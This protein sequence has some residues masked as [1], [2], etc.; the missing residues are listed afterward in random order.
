VYSRSIVD[1]LGGWKLS[2]RAGRLGVGLLGAFDEHPTGSTIAVD[3]ATGEVLPGWGAAETAGR[4]ALDQVAR[5]RWD[6]GGGASIGALFADR[7]L[8]PWGPTPA[9]GTLGN[10]VGAL[11]ASVPLSRRWRAE[12]QAAVSQT[13]LEDGGS[14]AGPAWEAGVERVGEKLSVFLEQFGAGGGFRA[15]NGFLEE[16]G[17]VGAEAKVQAHFRSLSFSRSFSPDLKGEVVTDFAGRPTEARLGPGWEV[18]L[19]EKAYSEGRVALV[20]ERFLGRDFDRWRTHGF[21]AVPP[22][23]TSNIYLDWDVGPTPH[24]EATTADDLFLGFAWQG[25]VGGFCALGG[26]ATLENDLTVYQFRRS[27]FGESVYDA[28]IDRAKL[29][30]NLTRPLSVRLVEQANTLDETLDSSLL[31]AWEK[32]YG[33]AAWLGY[34]E[35]FA[36]AGEWTARAIFAKFSYLWRP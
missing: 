22:T 15:E 4:A 19:G 28:V 8:V 2:G 20:R 35:T 24:Y 12:G 6:A 3:Y 33:T 23:I 13:E 1:P 26:R 29:N 18:F 21:A 31:L 27:A 5:T 36:F 32:D 34:Q 17:R 25:T 14:L 30:V 11:D 10:H 9:D 16:V 7:E